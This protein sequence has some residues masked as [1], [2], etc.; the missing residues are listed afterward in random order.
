MSAKLL[1][2][3]PTLPPPWT[4]AGQAPLS[5]GFPRQG[6]GSGLPFPFPEDLPNPWVEP[7]SLTSPA[8]AGGVFFFT[9]SATWEAPKV[10]GKYCLP[11]C[12]FSCNHFD[13][14]L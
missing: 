11:F 7:I 10:V 6:Y 2:S 3:C 9:T 5:V 12:E 14:F 13:S 4:V 8:V 1:Q